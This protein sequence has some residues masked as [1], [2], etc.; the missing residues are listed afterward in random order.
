LVDLARWFWGEPEEIRFIRYSSKDSNDPGVDF[1]L[2]F[3]GGM[4]AYFLHVLEA[5]Y[6]FVDVDILTER[7]RV[8]ISQRGQSVSEYHT[9]PEPYYRVFDI[10]ETA[11]RTETEW[12]YCSLRAVEEIVSCLKNG[13]RTSCTLEDGYRAVE[14]C[15]EAMNENNSL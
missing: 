2:T 5:R 6:V 10:L 12:R 13:A 11:G 9:M 14:I 3:R 15:Q 7:G 8:V 1:A 4:P